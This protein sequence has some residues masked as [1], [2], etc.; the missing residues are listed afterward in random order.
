M[1]KGDQCDKRAIGKCGY[2]ARNEERKAIIDFA[3]SMDMA[4]LNTNYK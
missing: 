2:G 4:N 3:Y 1:E